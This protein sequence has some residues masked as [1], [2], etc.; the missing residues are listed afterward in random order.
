MRIF[1]L[2]VDLGPQG[3]A[4]RAIKAESEKAAIHLMRLKFPHC[5]S[6]SVLGSREQ[7]EAEVAEERRIRERPVIDT[8][9]AA[10][11]HAANSFR[12]GALIALFGAIASAMARGYGW[13]I[14]VTLAV[15]AFGIWKCLQARSTRRQADLK[16]RLKR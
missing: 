13:L 11:V 15:T 4:T 10:T 12:N 14:Y 6:V 8:E 1:E 9:K 2:R 3:P 5:R 7:T 16:R